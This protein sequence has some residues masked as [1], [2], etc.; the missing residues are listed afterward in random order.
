M[1]HLTTFGFVRH[2]V[3]LWNKEGRA[4]GSSDVPLDEEGIAMAERVAERLAGEQWD[5]VYTSP[6]IRAKKTAEIIAGKKHGVELK[7][8]NRLREIG[9]GL[10]EGTLEAERIEKWGTKWRELD[11]GFEPHEEIIA[12]G[13][14][15]IE[16]MREIH[17]GKRVLVVSH[18]GFIGRLIEVLV[19]DEKLGRDLK[20]TSISIVELQDK[21]S[22][23]HLYNCIQHLA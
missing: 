18:G 8:D 22:R 23:C 17:T 3:T 7:L 9:G 1:V 19:P 5:V 6:L 11:L 21:E 12:R 2:G 20:N 4:Q 15:F 10:V 13:M 16:E 14:E